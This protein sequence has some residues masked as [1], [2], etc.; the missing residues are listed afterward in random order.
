MR[1]NSV[2]S[3][4]NFGYEQW[5]KIFNLKEAAKTLNFLLDHGITDY[6]ELTVR[7]KTAGESFDTL[8]VRIKQLEGRMADKAQI[9]MHIIN[10]SKTRDTY[11][12]YTKSHHKKEYYAAHMEEIK[13][14][15]AAKA[16][17]DALGGKPVPKV[18]Q[19]SKEYA[20]LLL[21]KK[22]CYEEYKT[23]WKKMIEYQK[24]KQNIDRILGLELSKQ[25]S[26]KETQ[27]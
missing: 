4:W 13:K 25:E 6:D 11:K 24:A 12:E 14:H 26:Q 19:L 9:K 21:E 20:E 2:E 8:S 10:Y 18:A 15:E 5:A 1:S 7:S 3:H 17:F 22:A 16:A 27:R 23:A